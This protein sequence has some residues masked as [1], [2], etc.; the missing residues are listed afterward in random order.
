MEKTVKI[1]SKGQITIPGEVRALLGS[2]LVRIITEGDSVRLE[3]VKDMGASL[4][5]YATRFISVKKAR[6]K[7]WT[8]VVSE[9]HLRD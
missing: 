1:S 8:E 4:K 7:A 5:G 9:K 6:E 2:N 3:P